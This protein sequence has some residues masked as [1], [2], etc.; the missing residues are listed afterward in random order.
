MA[1]KK[2]PERRQ[3]RGTADLV[4]LPGG[5]AV[6]V[7]PA[8]ARLLKVTRDAWDSFWADPLL[9]PLVRPSDRVALV[10]LFRLYDERERAERAYTRERATEGSTGQMVVNPFARQVASIDTR[11]DKL[12]PRFGITPKARL[13]LGVA[14]GAAHKSLEEMNRAFE[15]DDEDEGDE[16]DPR[17]AA[18]ESRASG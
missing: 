7:P 8:P 1:P 16:V 5:V 2:S 11:I 3:G 10:R 4:V 17:L 12:E 14:M 13:D 9:A 6:D 18:I 15:D